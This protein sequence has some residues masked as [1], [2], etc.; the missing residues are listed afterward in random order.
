MQFWFWTIL[1]IRQC[2]FAPIRAHH[3]LAISFPFSFS[4]TSLPLSCCSFLMDAFI[5]VSHIALLLHVMPFPL[6]ALRHR[7]R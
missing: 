6:T 1:V 3:F 7:R 4:A 2:Q 5:F